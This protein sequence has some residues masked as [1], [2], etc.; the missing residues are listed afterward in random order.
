MGEGEGEGGVETGG[1][2]VTRGTGASREGEE[3][4]E[5]GSGTVEVV[6][7]VVATATSRVAAVVGMDSPL[8]GTIVE[9]EEEVMAAG[10]EVMEEE[11]EVM[12][13][14]EEVRRREWLGR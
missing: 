7:M 3:E 8:E 4:G 1:R 12:A 6:A 14:G 2:E 5:G 10:E 11:E 9:E 13:A